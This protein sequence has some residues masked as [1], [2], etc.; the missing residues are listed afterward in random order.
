MVPVIHDSL[1]LSL[2]ARS[3]RLCYAPSFSIHAVFSLNTIAR[4]R[5]TL[6]ARH[7]AWGDDF[8][9]FR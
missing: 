8:C 6:A 3:V 2:L 7:I 1:N 5:L 4:S 9:G